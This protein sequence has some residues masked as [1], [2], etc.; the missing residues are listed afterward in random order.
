MDI[1][2]NE[3]RW[4]SDSA[5]NSFGVST[6][7]K[8]PSAKE[9]SKVK[10]KKEKGKKI[11]EKPVVESESDSDTPPMT[12]VKYKDDI[13]NVVRTALEGAKDTVNPSEQTPVEVPS[14]PTLPSSLSFTPRVPDSKVN[15]LECYE[16]EPVKLEAYH[17]E[18]KTLYISELESEEDTPVVF[19]GADIYNSVLSTEPLTQEN[20]FELT[21]LE[22]KKGGNSSQRL[23][24][25]LSEARDG[26]SEVQRPEKEE[27]EAVGATTFR[28]TEGMIP[29]DAWK[30][31]EMSDLKGILPEIGTHRIDI[32]PDAVPASSTPF[33]HPT[34]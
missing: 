6:R 22:D 24:D 16:A 11:K 13:S 3:D 15:Y 30:E 5:W 8:K 20:D 1:P 10:S 17:E 29:R 21:A 12:P 2:S 28:M 34:G 23:T 14:V 27:T 25:L 31:L 7:S 33:C 9:E 4:P 18:L 19:K 32:K 26:I